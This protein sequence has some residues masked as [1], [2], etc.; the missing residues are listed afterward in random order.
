MN[1]YV[2]AVS[3]AL[4]GKPLNTKDKYSFD[5]PPI[6]SHKDWQKMLDGAWKD[7]ELFASLVEK[8]AL[9]SSGKTF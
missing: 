4:K 6:H 8:C 2:K 7:A 1:D 5:L 9:K 3:E